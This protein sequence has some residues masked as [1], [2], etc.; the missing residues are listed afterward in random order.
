M[1]KFKEQTCHI[2]SFMKGR[3][4][5]NIKK[6]RHKYLE[7]QQYK[8]TSGRNEQPLNNNKSEQHQTYQLTPR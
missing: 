7:L 1:F 5:T 2:Q 3:D 8:Q 4:T 6:V